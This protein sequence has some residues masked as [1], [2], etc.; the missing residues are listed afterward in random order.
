VVT[1]PFAPEVKFRYVLAY[2]TLLQR[3]ETL[4]TFV[5]IVRRYF[6]SDDCLQ[7]IRPAALEPLTAS[8]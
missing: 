3:T 8:R 7:A 6:E 1:R 4:K 5:G 2:P